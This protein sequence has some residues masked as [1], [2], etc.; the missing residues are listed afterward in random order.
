MPMLLSQSAETGRAN[1]KLPVLA[2]IVLSCPTLVAAADPAWQEARNAALDRG[3]LQ[4]DVAGTVSRLQALSRAEPDNA[5]ARAWLSRA[6]VT[7]G[8]PGDALAEAELAVRL[9]PSSGNAQFARSQALLASGRR[10]EALNLALRAIRSDEVEHSA[11]TRAALVFSAVSLL[12]EEGDYAAAESL[13]LEANPSLGELGDRPQPASVDDI[14]G[15]WHGIQTLAAICIATGRVAQAKRLSARL[16]LLTEAFFRAQGGGDLNG[17]MRWN[18]AATGV[19][20][21]DNDA[22]ID[23]LESAVDAGF[24]LDWRYNYAQHPALRPLHG[25]PR[26]DALIGRLERETSRR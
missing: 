23:Y 6:L 18:L 22:A 17:P 4:G 14:G 5:D 2:A 8:A 20:R 15:S 25:N 9:D 7:V 19:G 21:I 11:G 10:A 24:L 26:F 1:R 16:A 3:Y 12:M 13:L